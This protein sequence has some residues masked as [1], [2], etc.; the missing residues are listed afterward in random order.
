[1]GTPSMV[2]NRKKVV[3]QTPST[4][5]TIDLSAKTAAFNDVNVPI[6]MPESSRQSLAE[7]A[8]DTTAQLLDKDAIAQAVEKIPYLNW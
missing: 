1:M 3:K 2:W 4:S 8:W 6:D 7:G 5:I